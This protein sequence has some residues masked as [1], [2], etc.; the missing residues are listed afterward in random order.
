MSRN[1]LLYS[2][3]REQTG[4][5]AAQTQRPNTEQPRRR[6][7]G[8]STPF[9]SPWHK[10]NL[11]VRNILNFISNQKRLIKQCRERWNCAGLRVYVCWW[12]CV[13]FG[14][15]EVAND[16]STYLI[17]FKQSNENISA[18]VRKHEHFVDVWRLK[19]I[20][21]WILWRRR[22]EG[23]VLS[24]FPFYVFVIFVRPAAGG[25]RSNGKWSFNR[26]KN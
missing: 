22:A 16:R 2:I 12:L 6:I 21:I 18:I 20:V 14:R 3:Y 13:L 5:A 8:S 15:M 1:I 19:I 10:Q 24:H 25:K 7:R 26:N 23:E 17:L 11:W 9:Y 4:L